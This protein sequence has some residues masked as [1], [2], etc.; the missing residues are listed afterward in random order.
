MNLLIILKNNI[1]ENKVKFFLTI[2]LLSLLSR[3]IIAYYYGDRTLENE[4][5]ILVNN[6]YNFGVF[7]LLRFGDLFVP[8]LWMP[9]IYGYFIYL[10]TI[11]FGIGQSLV[12]SVIISQIIIS[13]FTPIIFYKITSTFFNKNLSLIGALIFSLFPI[14]VFSASQISSVT[15]Y[16]FLLLI[17]F[18]FFLEFCS[19]QAYRLAVLIAAISGILILTRRDFVL[20]YFFSIFFSYFFFKVNL[21]KIL[22]I[23]MITI[24]TISPYLIKNYLVFDK[25]IIHSGFGYNVWKA[26]NPNAKAEGYYIQSDDLKIKLDKI[27][28]NV[29]YRINEDKVYLTKAKHYIKDE[30]S[31]YFKLFLN[32]IFSYYFIDLNSSQTNY[33]NQF[34]VIP[35]IVFA[36]LS[37]AGIIVFNKKNFKYNYLILTMFLIIFIYSCFAI[38]PRYK[39]YIL[40]FQILLSLNLLEYFIEKLSKKN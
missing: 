29:F 27:E 2:F 35:N 12:I 18:Y 32:R 36:I 30:P 24:I 13:S 4:W 3:S 6:L 11:F 1:I 14:I 15:I 25:I 21:K 26:Y 23:I 22:F 19:S 33:F 31:K 7:S 20:I 28:K 38:L 10:H 37:I 40:P 34:H 8:N 16:L 9:P 17:F 39:I 5:S